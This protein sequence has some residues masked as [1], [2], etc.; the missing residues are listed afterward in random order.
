MARLSPF[1]PFHA[2]E[3]S[4]S[5]V[6]RLA[7]FHIRGP[8]ST[9]LRDLGFDLIGFTTG[10]PDEIMRF[11]ALA[12]QDPVPVLRN[13]LIRQNG[14]THRL[15]E[16]TLIDR[17]SLTR[18]IRFCPA[19]LVQDDVEAAAA[20]Q[21]TAIYRRERLIWRLRAARFCLA[22]GLQ[23][24][25]RE[26]S[27]KAEDRGVFTSCVPETTAELEDIAKNSKAALLSPLQTYLENRIRGR[28]GHAWLDG[29]PLVQVIRV[30]ELLGAALVF[31]PHTEFDDLSA[32]E[33][34]IAST[35]GW[36]YTSKGETGVRAAFQ[37][38]HECQASILRKRRGRK[39]CSLGS[40][41]KEIRFLRWEGPLRR[42]LDEHR[43][44][45][46]RV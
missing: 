39:S 10:E 4:W 8:V 11:C 5:W 3:T 25:G 13:T 12:G 33:Q 42:L 22:H 21:N 37:I 19:C 23:L 43:I 2:D 6:A 35:I 7:A 44:A 30:T 40:L 14:R 1:L 31:G 24:I 36:D 18:N 27:G 16:D 15:G 26:R 34:E 9:F 38:L 20:K 32:R 29:Q 17:L 41:A 45:H 46:A 28:S